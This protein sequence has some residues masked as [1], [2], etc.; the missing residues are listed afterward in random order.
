[1][2]VLKARCPECDSKVRRTVDEPGEYTLKCPD[3]GHRF[4]AE[5]DDDDADDRPARYRP[6]EAGKSKAP[7]IVGL[8]AGGVL[9][10][11]AVVA[12]VAF[13]GKDNKPVA[14]ADPPAKAKPKADPPP[15]KLPNANQTPPKKDP[16]PV[17][18]PAGPMGDPVEVPP[19]PPVAPPVAPPV[20]PAPAD[21][22][23][24]PVA[25]APRVDPAEDAFV[26][27]AAFKLDGP[28]PELPP[29]PPAD[30]RPL[31]VLDPG[32]HTAFIRF[33]AF[34]PDGTRVISVSED[35]SVRLWDISTGEPVY[36]VRMP[37]GPADVGKPYS[38]ALSPDGTRLAISPFPLNEGRSGIRI[39]V[40]AVETG[41][42]LFTVNGPR[43][44]ATSMDFSPDGKFLA[45]GCAGGGLQVYEFASKKWVVNLPAAH[46]ENI[47][48]VRFHPKR[49]VLAT[50]AHDKQVK[51][52]ALDRAEPVA[53]FKPGEID[54][55]G[56]DWFS[57]GSALAV[58]GGVSGEV[59]LY[60]PDGKLLKTLPP[61]RAD[62]NRVIQIARMKVLPGDKQIV[63]GGV[64]AI[65]WAGLI[66]V[67]TGKRPVVRDH[68]NTVMAVNHSADGALC[69]S[70]GGDLN[71]IIVWDAKT[72]EVVR[73]FHP[74][75]Q[76][77]WAVGWA[78]NGKALA[79]GTT[80][81]FGAD[82]LCA[83]EQTLRLEELQMGAPPQPGDFARQVHDDGTYS[84][85]IENFGEFTVFENGKPLY[86]HKGSNR[87]YSV[88]IL[89][90]KGIVVGGSFSMYLLETKTGKQ[91][92]QFVG[93]AGLTTALTPSPDGRY[94]VSGS[95]DM[96][97][98]VWAP[99][100][101]EPVLSVFAAG[102][103]W[104][105]WTPQGYYACS[106]F[107]ERLIGWQVNNGID[108]LPDVHPAARFR[109]SLYQP[110]L[111]KYLIPAGDIRLAQ[112][113]AVKF[114]KQAAVAVGLADVLPP[115]VTV[116]APVTA[117]NKPIT[118]RAVAQGSEKNPIV[119]MRL[120][121]D[122]RPFN[123]AAGVKRFD[124]LV[125]AEASW[126]VPLG[127]GKHTVAVLAVSPVSKAM[128][129]VATVT[130]A[131]VP[132]LPNLYV[133]AMG[134]SDYPGPMKLNYAA[135]DALLLT[136]TLQE[137]SRKVFKKIEMKILTDKDC[138]KKG[139]QEGLD[140]L[141]S[142]MT[143]RDV[144]I[145][146]FSGHGGRDD[147]TGKFY[148][149]PVDVGRNLDK[150]CFSGEELKERL[151]DMPGRIIA[152]LDACHSGAVTEIKAGRPDN[153]VRDLI[154]DDYGVVVMASSLGSECSMESS[155]TRAGFYTLGLTEGM[156]GKADFNKDGV[157]QLNELERYAS[158]R[159]Q[160]LSQGRQNPTVG[161]PPSVKPFPIAKP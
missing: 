142:K 101:S 126:D 3:C 15:P 55:S 41:E 106:P 86:R 140:W 76:S 69:V 23:E 71:E 95:T 25:V 92:R 119:A 59:L 129:Q 127:P 53:Q 8:V 151:E 109:A 124:K 68:T 96:V 132:E 16:E 2:A 27:A 72:G 160:Q 97:M 18:M 28:L 60:S 73:N 144:G 35:K 40:L 32:G 31:L 136:R 115:G 39:Y 62:G 138:T 110:A 94:F 147:D 125:K 141:K 12:A 153:L 81:R 14:Q 5:L 93:D 91:L 88:T 87:I 65:G 158:L 78:K 33:V 21:P 100:R 75:T 89:P 49:P 134:V 66:D 85:K 26:R 34:T 83:L 51:V 22:V 11:G 104:I 50:V 116:T 148:L 111:I 156:S 48:D 84:I 44:P 46:S 133:L 112:A 135:S 36:T 149:I 113:M 128:S 105:A 79:W 47:K 123:G 70:A 57:D 37:S 10:I 63:F 56:I 120:L 52:W 9:L 152:I 38:A 6:K 161:R 7:I 24:P 99:D 143:D 121:V 61:A 154:T 159:V 117:D 145:V 108:K 58:G 82:K 29:L 103:E 20:G 1:M 19:R 150:T 45:A 155:A 131:G 74:Q 130:R 13:S 107:G 64:T 90:G 54:P 30:K 77:L 67:D 146:S 137:K 102:R 139:M 157:I 122:G 80:N 98:R 114:D 17:E 4:T 43:Q 42:L 118:V